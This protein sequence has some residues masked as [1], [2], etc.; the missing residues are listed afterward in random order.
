MFQYVIEIIKTCNQLVPTGESL[1]TVYWSKG[2][3]V[4]EALQEMSH[5][6]R[7]H[8]S[9]QVKPI[10][11]PLLDILSLQRHFRVL[12]KFA[13][14]ESRH[15]GCKRQRE[16]VFYTP[17]NHCDRRAWSPTAPSAIERQFQR[18]YPRLADRE[19]MS[20]AVWGR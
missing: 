13:H 14:L 2:T 7:D 1:T 4:P 16:V 20:A 6:L 18:P 19:A 10:D 3:Y 11:P 5:V 8:H 17:V 15:S 12:A 9:N